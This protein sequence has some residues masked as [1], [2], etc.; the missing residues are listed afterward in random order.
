MP[1]S[2]YRVNG[3]PVWPE[4]GNYVFTKLSKSNRARILSLTV[5]A[6][7]YDIR[8]VGVFY[9]ASPT[10]ELMNIVETDGTPE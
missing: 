1:K 4:K 9:C 6:P 5:A 8:V 2:S 7:N 3:F 10:T